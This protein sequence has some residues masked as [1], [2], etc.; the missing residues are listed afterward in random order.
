MHT[1]TIRVTLNVQIRSIYNALGR[2]K[3][4]QH[5]FN[6]VPIAILGAIGAILERCWGVLARTFIVT[7]IV[8]ARIIVL[9]VSILRVCMVVMR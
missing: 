2:A 4:P 9:F 1:Y 7:H 3:T 8:L 5:R 6:I